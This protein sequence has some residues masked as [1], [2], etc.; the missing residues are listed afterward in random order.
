MPR[1]NQSH[2]HSA[3]TDHPMHDLGDHMQPITQDQAHKKTGTHVDSSMPDHVSHP[4]T[5]AHAGHGTDHTGHEQI[6]RVR[7]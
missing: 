7:F 3:M 1:Q 6:F 5:T 2:N 4:M